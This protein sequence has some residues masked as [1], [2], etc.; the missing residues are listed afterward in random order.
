MIG[1]IFRIRPFPD[2]EWPEWSLP[3]RVPLIVYVIA[4]LPLIVWLA[5]VVWLVKLAL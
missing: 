5:I 2:D 1:M 3:P 4:L